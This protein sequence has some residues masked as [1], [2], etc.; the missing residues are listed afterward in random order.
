M[1]LDELIS[2]YN[3]HDCDI[4]FPIE[5]INCDVYVTFDLAKHLRYGAVKERYQ[6][7]IADKRYSVLVS[8]KF[9][10]CKEINVCEVL[11]KRSHEDKSVKRELTI[12]S[13]DWNLDFV[14]VKMDT[15][16][17][18]VSAYFQRGNKK[19]AYISFCSNQVEILKEICVDQETYDRLFDEHESH[20]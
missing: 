1:T 4:P 9:S 3:F 8:A 7:M 14:S 19:D 11:P 12:D 16:K 15:Y 2:E 17:N 20:A 18:E 6:S 5:Q 10:D 13:F